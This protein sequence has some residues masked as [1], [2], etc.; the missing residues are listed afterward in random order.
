M[1]IFHEVCAQAGTYFNPASP[2]SF[3]EAVHKLEDQAYRKQMTERGAEQAST[4]NWGESAQQL[5]KI[6]TR[7]DK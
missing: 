4:F 7:L 5:L 3:V 6:L 2:E 1:P